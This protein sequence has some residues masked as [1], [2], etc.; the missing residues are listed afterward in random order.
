[1][2][3]ALEM[4]AYRQARLPFARVVSSIRTSDPIRLGPDPTRIE[5]EG[6]DGLRGVVVVFQPRGQD[7]LPALTGMP[8]ESQWYSKSW[9]RPGQDH[10][11]LHMLRGAPRDLAC[12][13]PRSERIPESS[14]EDGAGGIAADLPAACISLPA[15][16]ATGS[17]RRYPVIYL[18]ASCAQGESLRTDLIGRADVILAQVDSGAT[19]GTTYFRDTEHAGAWEAG[20]E[21]LIRAVDRRYRTIATA[22]GRALLGYSEG[23]H[24]ALSLAFHRTDLFGATAAVSPFALDPVAW[25]VDEG[26]I[27][28]PWLTIARLEREVSGAGHIT[29]LSLQLD[30]AANPSDPAWPFDLRTGV[31][32]P[33]SWQRWLDARVI[34][35]L[36]DPVRTM[37]IRARLAGRI[38]LSAGRADQFGSHAAARHLHE[39]LD[40]LA[41]A[42]EWQPDSGDHHTGVPHRM[43]AAHDFL[44]RAFREPPPQLGNSEPGLEEAEP[45]RGGTDAPAT[46]GGSHA[47]SDRQPVSEGD[48]EP[49]GGTEQAAEPSVETPYYLE[50]REI[51]RVLRASDLAR[52]A[53]SEREP[54]STRGRVVVR[55]RI[56]LD[57]R[58]Q[59]AE[60]E[61]ST[62]GRGMDICVVATV[63]NLRF[64]APRGGEVQVVHPFDFVGEARSPAPRRP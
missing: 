4:Q 59:W 48:A 8:R 62:L 63:M 9:I 61:R 35:A 26:R 2:L 25:L 15:S 23:A 56:G 52:C 36:D 5:V 34:A 50:P 22:D 10:V 33:A 45:D 16:Y 3:P 64:P 57:G 43:S 38:F 21:R 39:R 24:S 54:A 11:V 19:F 40:A 17:G 58:V 28:E 49:A 31:I 20:L 53:A 55:W 6:P 18:L 32:E 14:A 12:H 1:M 29:S 60:I 42:H 46:E 37:R 51:V 7:P 44:V 41:I 47:E 27:R 30:P 13:G